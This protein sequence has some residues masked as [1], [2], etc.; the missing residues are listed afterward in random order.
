MA[1]VAAS[2]SGHIVARDKAEPNKRLFLPMKNNLGIEQAGRAFNIENKIIDGDIQTSCIVWSDETITITAD[3]AL[4][5]GQSNQISAVEEA[6]D[7]LLNILTDGAKNQ[8]QIEHSATE[9]GISLPTLKR[10]KKNLK[11]ISKKIDFDNGWVWSLPAKE[12]K[13]TEED[14]NSYTENLIPF[15]QN[16][17]LRQAKEIKTIE[18]DQKFV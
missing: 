17:P 4:G 1:F 14:Q 9:A 5:Y 6:E 11:I 18:E 8:K 2:R 3:E 16:D 7:F 13:T 12:I 15:E 10:A